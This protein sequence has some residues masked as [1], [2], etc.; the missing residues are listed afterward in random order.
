MSFNA[1]PFDTSQKASGTQSLHMHYGTGSFGQGSGYTTAPYFPIQA[2]DRLV[3]YMLVNPCAPPREVE[4]TWYAPGGIR[5]AY[6]GAALTGDESNK[7]SM[8][9]VP[10]GGSWVRMEVPANLLP[11]IE[12]SALSAVELSRFDGEVWLDRFGK[13]PGGNGSLSRPSDDGLLARAFTDNPNANLFM[14]FRNTLRRSLGLT[15]V[16]PPLSLYVGTPIALSSPSDAHR[17]SIYTP[18][19]NLMAETEQTTAATPAVAYEYIWFGGQP[20]AQVDTATNTTHWTFTDHLGTPILQT[21]AS[22]AVDWRVEYEPYGTTTTIRM[23][24]TRHQPLRFPGQEHD[25]AAADSTYNIF[26]WYT[27][28][29]GRYTQVD[30]LDMP[31]QEYAYGS[32]NPFRYTDRLGLFNTGQAAKHMARQAMNACE[33]K[34][35]SSWT[36]PVGMTIVA[37]FTADDANPEEFENQI[38]KCDKCKQCDEFNEAVRRAKQ[39]VGNL[40]ACR[41]G[42]SRGELMRRKAAWLELATARARRDMKCWGGETRVISKRSPMHGRRLETAIDCW[43]S[44]YRRLN[45]RSLQS[46]PPAQ[47]VLG[48]GRVGGT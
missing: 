21:N 33:E 40:G 47:V 31:G 19:L 27:S 41:A 20:V 13:A 7:V 22:G 16:N 36:G 9:A 34:A 38:K 11:G 25:E 10:A 15:R 2:G 23:G 5:G 28:S 44:E 29:L 35:G 3:L 32:E 39:S 17:Y 14:R 4:V 48:L 12:G 37:L 26:R 24:A 30:P 43:E 1:I 8:G 18:E 45:R 42:M 6:W 46:S